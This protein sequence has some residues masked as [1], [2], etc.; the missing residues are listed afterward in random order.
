M[1]QT[2]GTPT[3]ALGSLPHP[4]DLTTLTAPAA[5]AAAGPFCGLGQ[6]G[7]G[8]GQQGAANR[9]VAEGNGAPG[10]VL[11]PRLRKG[12]C[13]PVC[14]SLPLSPFWGPHQPFCLAYST[15]RSSPSMSSSTLL[16]RL[17][18]CDT[19]LAI[20]QKHCC[21]DCLE[22]SSRH[23]S[24]RFRCSQSSGDPVRSNPG[25][26]RQSKGRWPDRVSLRG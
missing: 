25:T 14:F 6:R 15:F 17:Y 3:H 23:W 13:L 9:R 1:I 5:A 19:G 4:V 18:S 24:Y 16:S 22:V 26:I 2:S 12:G 21:H 8:A 11:R 20:T 10:P 7:S